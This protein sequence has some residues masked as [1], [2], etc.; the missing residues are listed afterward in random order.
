MTEADDTD[1]RFSLY[2]ST[3][4][5]VNGR[6]PTYKKHRVLNGARTVLVELVMFRE[7]VP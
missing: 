2:L 4:V 3:I 7:G 1:E 5:T 6:T